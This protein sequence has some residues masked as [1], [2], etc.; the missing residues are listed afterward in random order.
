VRAHFVALDLRATIFLNFNYR[1]LQT[2]YWI[3]GCHQDRLIPDI[4]SVLKLGLAIQLAANV[5]AYFLKRAI[6]TL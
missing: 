1:L 3:S 4:F 2:T 6:L 5:C